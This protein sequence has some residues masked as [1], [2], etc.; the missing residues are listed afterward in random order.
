MVLLDEEKKAFSLVKIPSTTHN[1]KIT[2]KP[3][4]LKTKRLSK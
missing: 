4:E 1:T 2:T 3:K